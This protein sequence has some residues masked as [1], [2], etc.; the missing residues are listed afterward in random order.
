MWVHVCTA[1]LTWLVVLWSW[2][3]AGN[4]GRGTPPAVTERTQATAA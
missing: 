2:S 3:A 4:P 1:T